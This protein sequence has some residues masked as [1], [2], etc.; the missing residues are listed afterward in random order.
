MVSL[1]ALMAAVLVLVSGVALGAFRC[2]SDGG[3][4]TLYDTLKA[5]T[6]SGYSGGDGIYGFEGNDLLRGNPGNDAIH[7]SFGNDRVQGGSGSESIH[8]GNDEA[9]GYVECGPR[10][11]R[12]QLEGK[13]QY[14]T[15]CE[16]ITLA[17]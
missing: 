11:D 3:G 12:A 5:D 1:A 16:M 15:D 8:V 9:L 17:D 13:D 6:L 2:G 4:E 14:T 10:Y 7:A